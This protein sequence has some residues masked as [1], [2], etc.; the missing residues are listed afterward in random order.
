MKKVKCKCGSMCKPGKCCKKCGVK[1]PAPA[2][3]SLDM[4][5]QRLLALASEAAASIGLYIPSGYASTPREFVRL[6]RTAMTSY[7]LSAERQG[8]RLSPVVRMSGHW[9]DK[10]GRVIHGKGQSWDGTQHGAK[11]VPGQAAAPTAA[12]KAAEQKADAAT[13][14][15]MGG[16]AQQA[17]GGPTPDPGSEQPLPDDVV[18]LFTPEELALEKSATQP[19]PKD[20]GYHVLAEKGRDAD[21][22]LRELIDMG[23]GIGHKLGYETIAPGQMDK[24]A[25]GERLK[26]PGG[27]VLI[28]PLKGELAATAK[29]QGEYNGD[30]SQVLD[31]ARATIA[32]DSLN[33]VSGVIKKLREAGAVL[34]RQ[35]K[36]RFVKPVPGGYRDV[37][38]NI[39]TP[40]GMI[41]ELQVNTKAMLHA[42]EWGAGH[43][44]Y[45]TLR[46]IDRR[47]AAAKERI[48]T[49]EDQ[50]AYERGIQET[51]GAYNHAMS[52]S[53]KVYGAAFKKAQEASKPP[54]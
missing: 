22:W 15:P 37:L 52:E 24:A 8:L 14:A 44:Q 26:Q 1:M 4:R 51:R 9:M 11:W 17:S 3:L 50:L 21:K 34:A 30:W 6:S 42:K 47:H 18:N 29:V 28:G 32:V 2:Q 23:K 48:R 33:D 41:V 31:V 46:Q 49:P 54:D 13:G 53:E 19:I 36:N 20:A 38:M 12:P 16:Q 10:E 39:K 35:P 40:D 25:I 45:E 43:H 7:R 27:V 5:T